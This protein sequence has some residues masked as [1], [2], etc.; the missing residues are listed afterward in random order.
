MV[1]TDTIISS[2]INSPVRIIYARVELLCGSTLLD[3]FRYRDKLISFSIERVGDESK[4]FGY[5]ICHRLNVKVIDTNRELNITTANQL[6]IAFGVGS[7]YVYT[8]PLFYVSEVHRNETTNE[9]SI[10]AYDALYTASNHTVKELSVFGYGYTTRALAEDCAALMG[11]PF[12]IENVNDNSFS[13]YY[14]QGA[15]FEGNE[16]IREVLD[17]IAEATQTIYYINSEWV[18]VFKRLDMNGAAALTIDKEM[19]YSLDSKDNRRLTTIAH[20]TE[21]GDNLAANAATNPIVITKQPYNNNVSTNGTAIFSVEA[22]GESLTYQWEYLPLNT[23]VW[24]NN[25]MNGNTTNKLTFSAKDYHNGYMYRCLIKDASGNEIRTNEVL[26]TINNN[27]FRITYNPASIAANVGDNVEFTVSA[28]AASK[29]QW[30]Q[31]LNNADWYDMDGYTAANLSL[32]LNNSN[33][34]F[35][36]RCKVSNSAGEVL[37][38]DAA[39]I[40][41]ISFLSGTTQYVRNN[42]LWDMREDTAQLVENAISSLG[43]FTINQFNCEWRGNFLLEIGDKIELITKD[44]ESA[45]SYLLNDTIEYNGYYSQKTQWNYNNNDAETDSNPTTI[46]DAL[47]Q[48]YAKVDK[49]NKEIALMVSDIGAAK[50]DIA[51]ITLNTDSINATVSAI[52]ETTTNAISGVNDEIATL[53]NSV[54]ARM[55]EEDVKITIQNELSNGVDKVETNT[56]FTFNDEGLTVER[57]GS[58]MKTQITEDGML[59]Y[60]NGE[61]VLT[62]NNIGVDAVNLHATTYLII[63]NNSRFEDYGYGRTGCFWI[64]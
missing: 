3:T 16:S 63:G 41:P 34:L 21:L 37:Y 61:A 11:I 45:V 47:K 26:L 52:Q 38:S 32:E 36:Y 12:K 27:E 50:E 48:T 33:I 7:D 60:K 14:P 2:M 57:S 43:G 25:T 51:A 19:Y 15:N 13:T 22:R 30:Q 46:G 42:P 18:L 8:C 49:V 58:E 24:R 10:T 54:S 6:D 4:F 35:L 59:V 55:T 53:K 5:G 23:A 40:T 39:S 29:Y 17:A 44:D 64:G 9:L 62:A 31:S 56:G 1:N 20:I 28:R